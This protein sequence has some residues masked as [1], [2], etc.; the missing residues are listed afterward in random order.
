MLKIIVLICLFSNLHA[1]WRDVYA[2]GLI[3][4]EKKD[5][6]SAKDKFTQCI[7]GF[8]ALNDYEA[9]Y[10]YV[11]RAR[12]EELLQDDE[13]AFADVNK[14]IE[15]GRLDQN[16]LCRALTIRITCNSLLGNIP[17]VNRDLTNLRENSALV[18][19]I[20][21]S[22][23]Y[24]IVRN[25]L[26]QP[27]FKKLMTE[28]F[29]QTGECESAEDII[30]MN[31]NWIIERKKKA[32]EDCRCYNVSQMQYENCCANCD[33]LTAMGVTFCAGTFKGEACRQS[34]Y[35]TV[36]MIRDRLCYKCCAQGF[37]DTCVKPFSNIID[38]MDNTKCDPM[39]D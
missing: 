21:E 35:K 7:E 14:A 12:T 2:E 32:C 16:Q 37:Y 5:F 15:T 9:A 17:E 31:G 30:M 19:E 27:C 3:F 38:A 11:D 34:C 10:I 26:P 1:D 33:L 8:E 28:F 20:E 18:P 36:E 13:A 29:I 39:F 23:N 4:A 22:E 24:I 6:A 25:P